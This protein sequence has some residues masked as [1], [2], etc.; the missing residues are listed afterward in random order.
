MTYV[1]VTL[2]Y[3]CVT[4][5]TVENKQLIKLCKLYSIGSTVQPVQIINWSSIVQCVFYFVFTTFQSKLLMFII[6]NSAHD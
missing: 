3:I 2:N 6:L 4:I 5:Y 1:I